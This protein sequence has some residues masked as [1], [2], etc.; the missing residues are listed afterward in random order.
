MDRGCGQEGVSW[1]A[2]AVVVVAVSS[3]ILAQLTS[4][5]SPSMPSTQIQALNVSQF[6]MLAAA[7]VA[8]NFVH[9]G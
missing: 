7:A 9:Q 5:S 8:R 6:N 2:A 1:R 4:L 3:S